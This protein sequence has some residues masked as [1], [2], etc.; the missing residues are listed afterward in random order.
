LD[1]V[2]EAGAVFLVELVGVFVIFSDE[3]G[4]H[5][6]IVGFDGLEKHV[7]AFQLKGLSFLPHHIDNLLRFDVEEFSNAELMDEEFPEQCEFV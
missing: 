4:E 7:G 3:I 5:L 1:C 6:Q 2:G